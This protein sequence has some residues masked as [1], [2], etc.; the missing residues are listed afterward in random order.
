MA[1]VVA[2]VVAGLV[3]AFADPWFGALGPSSGVLH[4]SAARL[5]DAFRPSNVG[6]GVAMVAIVADELLFR[7]GLTRAAGPVRAGLVY[8]VVKAP[9]DPIGA[10]VS[11]AL[12]GSVGHRY[13]VSAAVLAHTI[14]WLVA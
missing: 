12:L 2:A 9:L 4:D 7:G 3:L 5:S 13:G 10:A 1:A 11:A 8:A 14:W 6:I